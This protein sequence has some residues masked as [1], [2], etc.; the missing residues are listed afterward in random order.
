MNAAFHQIAGRAAKQ[1]YLAGDPYQHFA[2][3]GGEGYANAENET[4]TSA[5]AHGSV[6]D[7]INFGLKGFWNEG[8]SGGHYQNMI[9]YTR[10][11]CGV[12]IDGDALSLAIDFR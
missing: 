8:P 10:V 5:T 6:R 11:G 1:D 2:L 9:K 3:T 4:I 12:F 7:G